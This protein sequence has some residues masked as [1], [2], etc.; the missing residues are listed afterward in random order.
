MRI[1]RCENQ[2]TTFEVEQD[3][4]KSNIFLH[5]SGLCIARFFLR[6]KYYGSDILA[7]ADKLVN[8]RLA[9]EGGAY[10]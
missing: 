10:L 6:D 8:S 2:H 9:G 1:W 3:S 4:L 5:L 7:D